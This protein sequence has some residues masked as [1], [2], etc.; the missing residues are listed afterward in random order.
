MYFLCAGRTALGNADGQQDL[1][2]GVPAA[3]ICVHAALPH[4][5]KPPVNAVEK[6]SHILDNVGGGALL[7]EYGHAIAVTTGAY[8]YGNNMYLGVP[9]D[10]AM[11]ADLTGEGMTLQEVFDAVTAAR[12]A[13][14]AAETEE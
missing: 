6:Q 12:E 5:L 8:V 3:Q 14:E 4:D 11:T 9:V 13:A 2:V 7:N 1:T 10:P